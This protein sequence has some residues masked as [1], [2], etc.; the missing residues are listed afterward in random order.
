MKLVDLAFCDRA[1]SYRKL[2]APARQVKAPVAA[3]TRAAA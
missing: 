3:V 1:I 2:D